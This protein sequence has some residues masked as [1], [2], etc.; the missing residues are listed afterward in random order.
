MAQAISCVHV[1]YFSWSLGVLL[2]VQLISWE[3]S[4]PKRAVT[5]LSG[6]LTLLIHFITAMMQH[7]C[8]YDVKLNINTLA[9]E[10]L[11]GNS[12]GLHYTT[13]MII[14]QHADSV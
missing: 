5:M 8:N 14:M 3:D 7:F 1:V 6:T 9:A 4:S 2:S 13:F 11:C 10:L 12:T